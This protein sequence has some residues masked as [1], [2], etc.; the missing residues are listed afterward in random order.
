LKLIT[1]KEL[2]LKGFATNGRHTIG[3]GVFTGGA[4]KMRV[5]TTLHPL[6][7]FI[8]N[9]NDRS[10]FQLQ[11]FNIFFHG[12]VPVFRLKSRQKILM[13]NNTTPLRSIYGINVHGP[14]SGGVGH[15]LMV[16]QVCDATPPLITCCSW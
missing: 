16:K 10:F 1:I 13:M 14:D 15:I 3:T 5:Q 11:F 4:A 8:T 9:M 7:F 2:Y 12:S 6:F